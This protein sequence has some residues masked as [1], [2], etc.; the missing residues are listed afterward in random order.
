[1]MKRGG[2]CG[3]L[4][5]SDLTLGRAPSTPGR[6][7]FFVASTESLSGP[8]GRGVSLARELRGPSRDRVPGRPQAEH[9]AI[10]TFRS[11][12]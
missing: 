8:G 7:R 2:D 12:E 1:M 3:V 10:E 6:A 9:A 11:G 5:D 4:S